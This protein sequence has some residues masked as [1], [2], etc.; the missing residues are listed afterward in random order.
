MP[1]KNI[2]LGMTKTEPRL[3][4]VMAKNKVTRIRVDSIVMDTKPIIIRYTKDY[5]IHILHEQFINRLK[6]NIDSDELKNKLSELSRKPLQTKTIIAVNFRHKEI[7]ILKN[8][9]NA[10][11]SGEKLKNYLS[12][13]EPIIEDYL[14]LGQYIEIINFA[15][16]DESSDSQMTENNIRRLV[17]IDSY[18]K[19]LAKYAKIDV[20]RENI[21]KNNICAVCNGKL[22]GMSYDE[23]SGDQYCLNCNSI[24][25]PSES[26]TYNEGIKVPSVTNKYD[27][28][29]TYKRELKQF[30]GIEKNKLPKNLDSKLDEYFIALR[31]PVGSEIRKRETDE[32]GKTEGTS[33]A[34]LCIALSAIG[35]SSLY[36]HANKIGKDYWGWKL[37]DL[38]K[39]MPLLINDF[40]VIQR[41]FPFVKKERSSNICSQHRI[42]HQLRLRNV[43]VTVTDF[44]FPGLEALLES[45]NIWKQM[46]E[47]TNIYPYI[48]TFPAEEMNFVSNKN[49][50]VIKIGSD[51][52]ICE[53][54]ENEKGETNMKK[55]I[56]KSS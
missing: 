49:G 13:A 25:T 22:I 39:L 27:V 54:V 17:I 4:R 42:F 34:A 53:F 50:I 6:S 26:L 12:E 31:F 18:F 29:I 30:Q 40:I 24:S 44:K 28:L 32:Y 14:S 38:E 48:P 3:D 52:V 23:T 16:E 9:I 45:E 2:I 46:V 7:E 36:K 20:Y 11:T 1:R 41:E 15:E 43:K 35:Y 21:I 33:L 19:V 55:I 5:Q 10:Y 56:Q 51:I 37:H 8:E 47:R